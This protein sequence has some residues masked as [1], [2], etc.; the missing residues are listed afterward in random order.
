MLVIF[1]K[2]TYLCIM[3]YIYRA[4]AGSGKTFLL[5]RFYIELLFRKEL[6]PALEGR[7]LLFSEILAVTFTNKATAEM[8]KRII[9]E[10]DTLRT[11]PKASSYYDC[12]IAPDSTGHQMSDEEIQKR[13]FEILKEMLT[14]YS[15]LHISTIDSF[16]QQVIRSFAHELNL[17]GNY[18]IELDAD[19]VLDNAVS[20]FLL[21]LDPDR[22]KETFQW[23]VRYS[24][25][26]LEEGAK[27]NVHGEL[28]KLAKLLT[29]EEFRLYS[30]RIKAFTSDKAQMAQYIEYLD[31]IIGQWKSDLKQIGTDCCRLLERDSLQPEQ[32]SGGA[33]SPATYFAR[34]C[35]GEEKMS[36]TLRNWSE[37]PQKWFAKASAKLLDSMGSDKDRL[38]ELLVQA[39]THL[40][41]DP[42]FRYNSALAIRKNIFQLGLLIQLDEA[43]NEYC[44]EQ[45]IKLLSDTTQILN[46]LIVGQSAPFIYEKTGTRIQSFMIDEFQ[47]TSGM[48]WANFEPLLRNSLG[49]NNRN[50]IVGDVKQSIYRWRGSDWALLH[51]RINSFMPEMQGYDEHHNQL[52]DNWRSDSRIIQFNN[53]FFEYAS[54]LLSNAGEEGDPLQEIANIYKDVQQTI[55]PARQK[56]GVAEGSVSFEILEASKADDYKEALAQRLP[57][58]VIALQQR[59]FKAS[60]ILILCRKRDQCHQC[61]QALMDYRATHPDLPYGMNIITQEALLLCKQPVIKALIAVLQFLHEPKSD[62][63]R[64]TAAICWQALTATS[65]S[66]A[67]SRYFSTGQCPDFEDLISLPLYE[68]VERLIGML[69]SVARRCTNFLQAFCD[70]VLSYCSKE[71]PDLDGFL[72]WWKQYGQGCSV[73]TPAQQ[74]AIRIMTIHQSKGLDGEAVIIPFAQDTLD[75]SIKGS[76]LLWCEPSGEFARPDL[77]LPIPLNKALLTNSVFAADYAVERMRAII[78][79]LNTIYVAFTRARHT[80]IMLSPQPAKTDNYDLQ[81]L[82]NKFFNE[83]WQGGNE[84]FEVDE[85]QLARDTALR[86]QGLA[87]ATTSRASALPVF[88]QP[89]LPTIKE[90]GYIPPDDSAAA[91]GTTLHAA[92]SA[93]IDCHHIDDPIRRLFASGQA[94]LKGY[95]LE[96]VLDH[97]HKALSN[98]QV[99]TWFDPANRVLNERDIITRTTHTQRPDR[100][101]FTPDGRVIVID[102]KTGDAHDKQYQRQVSH[103]MSL[104]T[105]MGF[106]R[107]EGYIWYVETGQIVPVILS[108]K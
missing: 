79:N 18:E 81:C 58:L 46:A 63:R 98:P 4:S 19:M 8:K 37:D 38:Q 60:D 72:Y 52:R 17:Q 1:D 75:L 47:D 3:L 27:W 6:T 49:T 102:Y 105:D 41:G 5:T 59:G 14:D 54:T 22:D 11:D 13:A 15:S 35:K 97:V 108:K 64:A 66:E 55:H 16:F 84:R 45:G 82:L 34:W 90:T 88:T 56:K 12:L 65:V 106:S 50:L 76:D 42:R 85:D 31:H 73:T 87:A 21:R 39:V 40:E 7:N 53:E 30:D 71:G 78:D 99:S 44:S 92:F 2:S 103:Y 77:V 26:R 89:Q 101:V 68:T 69:P 51:S 95:T 83:R 62:Y 20:Q 107:T 36:K 67:I 74:D 91:R 25:A 96:E 32:F 10:L 80:M 33:K 86:Q 9:D 61:A 29:T 43:A 48:Q 93:I 24:N 28:L 94:A 104:L 57:Q 70:V 100:L 23:I